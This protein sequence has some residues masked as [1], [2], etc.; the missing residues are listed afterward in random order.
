MGM[1]AQFFLTFSTEPCPHTF[2]VSIPIQTFYFHF[3][4][5]FVLVSARTFARVLIVY[6]FHP[7]EKKERKGCLSSKFKD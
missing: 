1:K 5:D 7:E 3:V 2:I 4:C 6:I